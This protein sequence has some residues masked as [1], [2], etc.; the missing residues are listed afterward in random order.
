MRRREGEWDTDRAGD[1]ERVKLFAVF[2]AE[3]ESERERT[4]LLYY[5]DASAERAARGLH[6]VPAFLTLMEVDGR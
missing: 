1:R 3:R 6:L 5:N 2:N 4:R